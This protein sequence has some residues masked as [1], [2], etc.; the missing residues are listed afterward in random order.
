MTTKRSYR[1]TQR[2]PLYLLVAVLLLG[3]IGL[4][5][6]RRYE[7]THRPVDIWTLV[8]DDAVAVLETTASPTAV[9]ELRRSDLWTTFQAAPMVQ[10]I[11][12]LIGRADSIHATPR[13]P[14]NRFLT[15]K[16]LL[17]SWH[18]TTDSAGA[19]LLF[20]IPIVSVRQYRYLRILTEDL[21]R[22]GQFRVTRREVG[23]LFTTQLTRISGVA[24]E[25]GPVLTYAVYRNVLLASAS[26]ELLETAVLRIARR[27]LTSPAAAFA[28]TDYLRVRGTTANLWINFRQLPAALTPWLGAATRPAADELASLC[29]E[30]MLGLEARDGGVSLRG[31]ASPET[32]TGALAGRLGQQVPQA[33][34]VWPLLPARAGLILHLGMQQLRGLRRAPTALNR[35]PDA[36]P[37]SV[38]T[39]S[40]ALLDSLGATFS[41]E[42][43]LCLA[44]AA[45]GA[46]GRVLPLTVGSFG[47]ER[48]VYAYT[49][50]PLRTVRALSR[51]PGG[52]GRTELVAGYVVRP[53]R[54]AELPRRLF[55]PL[56]N[57]FGSRTDGAVALVGHYA[58]FAPTAA[59]LRQLLIELR[60]GQTLDRAPGLAA[61]LR[62]GQP[63]AT[64]TL[65]V[66]TANGWG[67]L[68]RALR[69]A[70]RV[71]LLR[72]ELVIRRF[73]Q[74][75]LQFSRPD[76]ADPQLYTTLL[77]EHT[78]TAGA[79]VVAPEGGTAAGAVTTVTATFPEALTSAP[80]LVRGGLG[81]PEL[82]V[83]DG[84]GR[85]HALDGAGRE[86]WIDTL[87]GQAAGP[88]FRTPTGIGRARLLLATRNRLYSIEA[89]TGRISENFP[90]YL[91]DSLRMQHL[92]G[93]A[94]EGSDYRLLT[95]DPVGNLYAFDVS[96]R[97]V[98]G[99]EGRFLGA[100]L[101]DAPRAVRLDGRDYVAVALVNGDLYVLD[102]AGGVLPGF[103]VSAGAPLGP[104]CLALQTGASARTTQ[105][106]VCT[107]GGELTAFNLRGET[108]RR[109]LLP[110]AGAGA[111]FRLI[112]VQ[113]GTAGAEPMGAFVVSRQAEGRVT[114]F[115]PTTGATLLNRAFLTAS[116]K[117]VQAYRLNGG[118]GTVYAIL[119]RGPRKTTLCNERGQ[120]LGG[121]PLDSDG[122]VALTYNPTVAEL[123]V[124][125]ASGKTLRRVVI[126]KTL[127]D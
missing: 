83:Q 43:A 105:V 112:T 8:P 122:P 80:T 66:N 79:G 88:F 123:V 98:P 61:L 47:V 42:V 27:G 127:S 29:R 53:V 75:L 23:G 69:P 20:C 32:A 11:D 24:A 95:Y 111:D 110:G 121:A 60:Q 5:G 99:W 1:F 64:V 85:L 109:Q 6:Y 38:E 78:A 90:F 87:A 68:Q 2:N 58:V 56:F 19:D 65:Y 102:R 45:A 55:G 62:R 10:E 54:V 124:W 104:G 46:N 40:G 93:F 3:A 36:V 100:P 34:T 94:P 25:N 103:P 72:N 7:A 49:P 96:G 13:S 17:I 51:L 117:E 67:L 101:A 106:A 12:E 84:A 4:S 50:D 126:K 115:D 81:G 41:R 21:A 30:G 73:P 118:G 48:L 9:A 37:D 89:A 120:L 18:P 59:A 92:T 39:T 114:L 119:E 28:A 26:R 71:S 57:G 108:V 97:A 35:A 76:P 70:R 125:V 116:P 113:N 16:R 22:S 82:V 74:I 33:I 91:A 14:L 86:V 63:A 77:V 31:F 107:P 52:R 15:G 44:G